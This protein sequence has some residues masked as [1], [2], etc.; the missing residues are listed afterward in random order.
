MNILSANTRSVGGI[1]FGQMIVEMPRD[2]KDQ[3]VVL[4][5]LT[6][7]GVTMTEVKQH[8]RS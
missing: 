1:G 7:H 5:Y 4:D 2:R 6:R 8:D 3:K